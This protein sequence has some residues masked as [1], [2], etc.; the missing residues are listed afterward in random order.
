MSTTKRD[1]IS[2]EIVHTPEIAPEEDSNE[3]D[4]IIEDIKTGGFPRNRKPPVL[5]LGTS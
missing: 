2:E 5:F 3:T 4:S 1:K